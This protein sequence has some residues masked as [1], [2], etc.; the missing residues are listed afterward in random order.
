[1]E[2]YLLDQWMYIQILKVSFPFG[3]AVIENQK[4]LD[5]FYE[6]LLQARAATYC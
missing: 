3:P 4:S 5:H 6:K 1:M 2:R